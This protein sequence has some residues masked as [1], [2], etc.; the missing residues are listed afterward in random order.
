MSRRLKPGTPAVLSIGMLSA[1]TASNVIPDTVRLE[2]TLRSLDP[3]TRRILHDEVRRRAARIAEAHG[4]E[5]RVSLEPGPPPIVNEAVPV[6]WARQAVASILGDGALVPLG[7]YNMA[8]EDFAFYLEKMA[9]CFLRIG[10]REEGGE[11]I[12]LHASRFYAA[13]EAIFVGSAVLAETARIASA[14]LAVG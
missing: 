1:G 12:P 4:L 6:E 5:A 14:R 9:G 2:G 7:S 10:A 8:G 13:D 3:E 11:F